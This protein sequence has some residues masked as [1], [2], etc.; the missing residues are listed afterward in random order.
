[1]KLLF[2][3]HRI[4]YPP[5]KGDKIRSFHELSAFVARGHEV[6]LLAFADD[7]RDLRYQE[8]L[9]EMCA[10]ATI[11]PLNR[12]WAKLRSLA[13]LF[14]H[15]PFSLGYFGSHRMRREVK[16]KLA[17]GGFDAVFVYSSTMAQYVPREFETRT[18]ADLVD[19]DSEKWRDY[20]HRTQ[21]L[22][23]WLYELEAHRLRRYEHAIVGRFAHTIVT[24]KR[25]AALLKDLDEFTR[26]AR[27]H[28]I[29]NGIDLEHYRPDA[30]FAPADVPENERRF[31]NDLSKPR[32]VFTGAMDYYANVD[33][34]RYFA[35]EVFPLIRQREPSAEFL[36]VGSN[37]TAEVKR[38]GEREGITVTSFVEDVRP[39][40]ASATVCMMPLR[41]ARGV[42][43]K[44]LEAMA[45]GRAVVATP[46]VVA[47]LR[48]ADG[49]HALIGRNAR[50]LANAALKVIEDEG[51]RMRLGAQ[52][53]RFVEEDHDWTPLLARLTD[54]V[55]S[56]SARGI[57]AEARWRDH[58]KA[59]R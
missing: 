47:G 34:M 6:H 12:S 17:E 5:N 46:E 49:E 44:I 52:A 31:L 42:Q 2:L 25:E 16:S 13:Y 26:R 56:V 11:I 35:D 59:W 51:L 29:T 10:S 43:N 37:P 32:L 3:A 22:V 50:E 41:I 53:R 33:G 45:A 48:V 57:A 4:P 38:L 58:A 7:A 55:E 9:A 28:T 19:I 8:T 54:L 24:T 15:A 30:V 40:L 18:V 36:I 21:S 27:L 39:Y 14:S 23:A 1:M 20:A